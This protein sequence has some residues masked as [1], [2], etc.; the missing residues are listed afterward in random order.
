MS[1]EEKDNEGLCP[2]CDSK[3]PLDATKC[4]ECKADLTLFGVKTGEDDESHD[5]I[6]IPDEESIEALLGGIKNGAKGDALFDEIMAAVDKTETGPT[7]EPGEPLVDEKIGEVTEEVAQAKA[8]ETPPAQKA[9][10]AEAIQEAISEPAAEPVMFECPLCNTLVA[11]DAST[12]P[13]CGAIFADSEEEVPAEEPPQ[14]APEAVAPQPEVA[15]AA[16]PKPPAAQ[17]DLEAKE[18]EKALRKELTKCVSDVKPLLAGA[19]QYGINVLEGRKLIDRAI[20]AGKKRDFEN[21]IILV[22]QSQVAIE[23]NFNQHIEDLIS[24]IQSK[25]GAIQKAGGNID[26][27]GSMVDEVRALVNGKNFIEAA[28]KVKTTSDHTEQTIMQ[29]KSQLREKKTDEASDVNQKVA[30]LV[31]LIKSGEEVKVNVKGAISFLTEARKAIKE[32]DYEKAEEYLIEA[33]EDFLKEL[34]KQI[35]D[36]ISNSKPMLYKAKM[37]GVDIRPSIKL[38]KEASTALKL[39]NY[40]DALDAIKRYRAEMNQ[41]LGES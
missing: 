3:V 41:Y 34:P 31:D 15:P 21:A 24:Q 36:I 17:P 10:A 5:E 16:E 8:Q 20:A 25:M 4:P 6:D 11:E 22:R 29:L 12:C 38:L 39:N 37:Q 30:N 40:L 23:E 2:I 13:G 32:G 26:D 7:E 1:D 28:K 19:R 14:A 35:T 9:P 18:K 33:K 27:L